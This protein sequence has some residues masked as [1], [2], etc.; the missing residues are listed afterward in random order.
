M[1]ADIMNCALKTEF[2]MFN[3]NKSEFSVI[4]AITSHPVE[5]TKNDLKHTP[6]HTHTHTHTH[7]NKNK[8]KP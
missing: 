8:K 5:A 6:T 3:A 2:C 4:M 1:V 7:T